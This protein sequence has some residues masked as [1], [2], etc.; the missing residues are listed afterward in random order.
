MAS[1]LGFGPRFLHSTG[2]LHKGGPENGIFIMI[3]NTPSEDA[4]I[5][6]EGI[7]FG[8]L[9]F[10]QALGDESALINRGRKVLRIHIHRKSIELL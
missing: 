3:T 7:T 10:A 4:T 8:K 6:G 9:C 2:Q 5:P 1:T